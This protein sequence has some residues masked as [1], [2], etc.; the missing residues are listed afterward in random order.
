LKYTDVSKVR[1][2]SIVIALMMKAVRASVTSIYYN[3]DYTAQYPRRLYF[4]CFRYTDFISLPASFIKCRSLGVIPDLYLRDPGFG[5]Q[6]EYRL[7]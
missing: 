5:C 6:L 4:S 2:A 7:S 1:T 3:E